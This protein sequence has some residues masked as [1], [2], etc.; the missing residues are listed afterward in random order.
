MKILPLIEENTTIDD[1]YADAFSEKYD[2]R[3]KKAFIVSVPK[4]GTY[5]VARVLH[6]LGF[7]D[8]EIHAKEAGL[9][10]YRKRSNVEKVERARQFDRA[11]PLEIAAQMVLPGQFLVGHIPFSPKN[12]E[13]MRS[14]VRFLC[15]RELRQSL[16]SFMRFEYRRLKADCEREPRFWIEEPIGPPMMRAY[17]S[18]HGADL[19]WL[20]EEV[21]KWVSEPGTVVCRFEDL[22]GD[23]GAACQ[24]QAAE[25]IAAAL[26]LERQAGYFAVCDALG[27][28]TL[29]YSGSRT[30]LDDFWDD[31][32]EA[33]FRELGGVERNR[34]LGYPD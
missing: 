4:S 1:C 12:R 8:L 14:F 19:L 21:F 18:V 17:L 31:K 34:I 13:I 16:A 9:T 32:V 6:N 23:N 20:A 7:V 5:L 15:L 33:Y 28:E 24:Q 3:G 30:C 26:G 22:L 27:K 29:T 2:A 11:I 25:N 10:D